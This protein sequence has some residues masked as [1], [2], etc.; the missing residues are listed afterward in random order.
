MYLPLLWSL[1]LLSVR[2]RVRVIFRLAVVWEVAYK[3][4]MV[5]G[6]MP[7]RACGRVGVLGRAVSRDADL[8]RVKVLGRDKVLG[9]DKAWGRVAEV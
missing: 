5:L 4:V 3:T 6:S 7:V 1:S 8:D 2:V 9:K